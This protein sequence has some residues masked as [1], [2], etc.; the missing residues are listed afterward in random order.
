MALRTLNFGKLYERYMKHWTV[1][2]LLTCWMVATGSSTVWNGENVSSGPDFLKANKQ[3]VDSVF[4]SMTLEERIGQLFMVA[5][6]SNKNEQHIRGLEELIAQNHI[7]GLIFFQGGPLRQA[8]MCN[9]LQ[10]KS[11][12]PMLIGMDAEWGISMRLDSTLRYPRQMT[13]GAIRNDSL[14]Y[15][16]GEAVADE[17]KRM[18]MHV[19]FAPVADINNNPK[20]PVINSRSFGELRDNVTRKSIAYMKGMQDNGVMANAKH[21]PGHGDTDTDSHKALPVITHSRKRLDSLELY[22]FQQMI[23]QGLAS[24]MVAHMYVPALDSSAKQASTLSRAIVHDLLRKEMGFDGL[25]FTDALNMKGVSDFV[26]PGELEYRALLAGNDILLFAEDVPKAVGLIKDAIERGDLSEKELNEHCMRVLRAKAWAGLDK[27]KPINTANLIKDLNASRAMALYHELTQASLTLL[28]N[29]EHIL[30]IP[31]GVDAKI[32]AIAVGDTDHKHY[33]EQL[34]EYAKVDYK[35]VSSSPTQTEID[36]LLTESATYDLVLVSVHNTNQRPNRNFGLSNEAIVMI[37]HLDNKNKVVLTHFGNPYALLKLQSLPTLDAVIVGYQDTEVTRKYAAQALFGGVA[38]NGVL[39]VSI[40]DCCP[41]GT[42]ETTP[43]I[44]FSMAL[45]EMV[46]VDG[47]KLAKIDS[48][49]RRGIEEMA[50]PGCQV[51]VARRGRVIYNKSF[52]Y[53]TYENVDPVRNSDLYDL[54]SLTKILASVPALMQLQDAGKIDLDKTLG[55]Y[56]S[57]I[58]ADSPY[59]R[60]T[61]RKVLAHQAGLL[62]WIPFYVKTLDKG[63][64]RSDLYSKTQSAAFPVRVSEDVYMSQAA[65]DTLIQRILGTKLRSESDMRSSEYKYSDLGYFFVKEIVEE[66]SGMSLDEFVQ[67]HFYTPLGLS[68][69]G[70][71]PRNRFPLDRITP[72]EYDTYYRKMLVHGDVHD[73]GAAM[74]GGVGGHAGVF[75][76]AYDVAVMMQ[77]LLNKGDYNGKRLLNAETIKEYTKCQFCVDELDKNR[78][79]AGFDKPVMDSGPGP[80][81]KCVTFDTFGHTGFTGTI[82]W[83]DPEQELVYV[84]LSNRVYPTAENKK[85][86]NMNIRTVIQEIIYDS[87]TD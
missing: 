43:K 22:P 28:G 47:Q 37:N 45:P 73:P 40:G 11:K 74:Q 1:A 76:N 67:T 13:L 26:K 24:A 34:S 64:L 57:F 59:Q 18:G 7:G 46:G 81:C 83:A 79:G 56:L 39:P 71:L 33:Q 50:Y 27:Y 29:K 54:A 44:E 6:Y 86:V 77:M 3:W 4:D 85:L 58:D 19:N 30:P 87:L 75:S 72:T 52:G 20:N 69:M 84:F 9:R 36:R 53:H 63:E 5:A 32:L 16:F 14:V 41:A 21:F 38:L 61:L 17:F 35:S 62:P 55:D 8:N 15:A 23:S 48:V 10:A 42:G 12:V 25:I 2:L 82:A 68:T 65:S 49:V 31:A 78:R 60:M 51:L 80:T 66:L 70:Y